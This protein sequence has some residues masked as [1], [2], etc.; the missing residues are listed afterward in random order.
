MIH[1]YEWRREK[2]SLSPLGYGSAEGADQSPMRFS[3]LSRYRPSGRAVDANTGHT[4]IRDSRISR[5]SSR[6]MIRV[7]ATELEL[8]APSTTAIPRIFAHATARGYIGHGSNVEY[9]KRTLR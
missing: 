6:E 7:A 3:K 4:D 1:V 9:R 5:F 8:S 2:A